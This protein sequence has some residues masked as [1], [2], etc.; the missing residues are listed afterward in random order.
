MPIRPTSARISSLTL[1]RNASVFAPEAWGLR[2]LLIGG[3]R[4]R[5]IGAADEPA[6]IMP[7]LNVVDLDGK[8][9]IPGLIDGTFRS[10]H[11]GQDGITPDQRPILGPAG[12]AGASSR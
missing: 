8:R 11:S 6:P 4:I 3:G 10:A 2:Q 5:W 7:G 12:P 1:I 9:L